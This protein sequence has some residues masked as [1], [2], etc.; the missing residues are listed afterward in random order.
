MF[1]N[2][3]MELTVEDR[4]DGVDR[5]DG[6]HRHH[7]KVERCLSVAGVRAMFFSKAGV[8]EGSVEGGGRFR[9]CDSDGVAGSLVE[10]ESD[11]V[12]QVRAT[13]HLG[14]LMRRVGVAVCLVW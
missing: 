9:K 3:I 10:D 6:S 8:E 5:S 1:L 12:A 2:Q 11:T 13:V 14:Y 4:R 7:L